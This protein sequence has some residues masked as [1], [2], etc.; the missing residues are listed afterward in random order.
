MCPPR[1]LAPLLLA[2]ALLRANPAPDAART[3]AAPAREIPFGIEAVTGYRSEY[4]YRGFKLAGH[5]FDFQLESEIA[6][7][8]ALTLDLGGWYATETDSGD[9]SHAA[10][11]ADL[12]YQW[13]DWSAGVALGYH[14]FTDPVFDDGFDTGAVVHWAPSDDLQFTTGAYYDHGSDGWYAKLEA[15]WS[16]PIG[17]KSFL[18]LLGGVSWLDDYYGRAGWNDAYARL[19]WTFTISERVS[20]TP[21]VG[22]SLSLDSGPAS[23]SDSLFAGIWFEVNF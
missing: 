17:G 21:F 22:T 11:F 16:H 23:G 12:R 1:L 15:A 2:P 5:V 19:A 13:T 9:F 18:E 7:G 6:L 20:L 3:L 14:N 10:G 8:N 4:V